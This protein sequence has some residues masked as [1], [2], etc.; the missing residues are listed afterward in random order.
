MIT[1]NVTAK[2]KA[3]AWTLEAKDKTVG[4]RPRPSKFGPAEPLG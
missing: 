2:A 4:P 1:F 3:K